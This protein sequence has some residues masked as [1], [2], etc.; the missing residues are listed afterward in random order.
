VRREGRLLVAADAEELAH[1]EI[2]GVH[3]DV[4][5]ELRLPVAGRVLAREEVR[6]A[7]LERGARTGLELA[8]LHQAA[9]RARAVRRSASAASAAARPLRTAPSIVAG[10]PVAVHAPARKRPG[11]AVREGGRSAREPGAWRNV[12]AGSRVVKK[13]RTCASRAAGSKASRAGRN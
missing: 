8:A 7:A 12:A 4:G 1:Q 13:S 6:A 9:F 5:L 3:R 11:A 10:Q 2:F